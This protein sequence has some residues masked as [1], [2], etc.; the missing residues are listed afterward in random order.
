MAD[1]F[2]FGG[3]PWARVSEGSWSFWPGDFSGKGR[4]DVLAYESKSGNVFV[5]RNTGLS[6]EGYAWP[7]SARPG[8]TI[9]FMVSGLASSTVDFF[10]HT[11]GAEGVDS[12]PKRST[13]F[14]PSFQPV[15]AHSWENGLVGKRASRSRS[16]R[17]GSLES[18]L[19]ASPL[20]RGMTIRMCP[21][22]LNPIMASIPALRY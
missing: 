16:H 21:L 15:Q 3:G 11:A 14:V 13:N 18:T 9:E 2:Y 10:K 20:P 1:Q 12:I 22:L 6:P 4:L 8:E 17:T 19:R 7:L 5:G